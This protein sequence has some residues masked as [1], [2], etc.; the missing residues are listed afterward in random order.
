LKVEQTDEP[1]NKPDSILE[2]LI[3]AGL[4]S[5]LQAAT[6]GKAM[7]GERRVVTILFCDVQGST[8]ASQD[9]DPEEWAEI[10]NGVFEQMISPIYRYEGF[11]ARL[12]GD[13]ILAFFGAPIA[14]ED[15]P[16]RAVLAG[17]DI[18][19]AIE[20]YSEQLFQE[21]GLRLAARVGINT[22]LVVVGTVGSD[23]RMEYT[24]MGD[25]I[26]LAARMEQTAQ[27][28]SVQISAE[29]H[30][31]V[32]PYFISEDLGT[33]EIKGK[34]E[35]IQIFN[36]TAPLPGERKQPLDDQVSPLIGREAEFNAI[37]DPLEALQRGMG[38][39]VYLSGEAGL[40]KSRLVSE[41][42]SQVDPGE[43]FSWF[44]TYSLSYESSQPYASFKHL[45][46]EMINIFPDQ[47]LQEQERKI[48]EFVQNSQLDE[49]DQFIQVI[50]ALF[51]I[52]ISADQPALE[53]EGFRGMLYASTLDFW[54]T[55]AATLPVVLFFDDLQWAD[56]AT[57]G[58]LERMFSLV[59]QVPLLLICATRPERESA[60]WGS[61]LTAESKFPHRFTQIELQPLSGVHSEKLVDSLIDISSFP[62][63]MRKRILEKADGNPYF[64]EEVVRSLLDQGL[65]ISPGNG[66]QLGSA[67]L[68]EDINIPDNLQSLL[69]ARIDSLEENSRW[70]LQ[71][72]A[73]IGRKFYYQV[74]SRLVDITQGL[75]QHLVSLQRQQLIQ[76]AA[77]LPEL[78]YIFKNVLIQEAAYGTLLIREK[79]HY[80]RLVAQ[81][82]EEIFPEQT[83][84][85]API[86]AYHC[87]LGDDPQ[88]A[89]SYYRIAG[90]E[91]FRLFATGEAINHY[92][93]ALG[94]LLSLD[95]GEYQS[96]QDSRQ[97]LLKHL[98]LRKG[99]ALELNQQF[100]LA[101]SSYT[102]MLDYSKEIES[103]ALEL[104]AQTAMLTLHSIP[105]PNFDI[106][107]ANSI[108]KSALSLA[109]QLD[110]QVAEA[111]VYWSL[112]I[113]NVMSRDSKNAIGFANKSIALS[114]ELN[115][116]EQLA[117]ALNDLA[118]AYVG[119]GE[120]DKA[121]SV[122]DEAYLLFE[123]LG[124]MPML[125]DN[126]LNSAEINLALGNY[127]LAYGQYLEIVEIAEGI[128]N[129]WLKAWGLTGTGHISLEYG[130]I[131]QGLEML[132]EVVA[133]T[134]QIGIEMLAAGTRS[135]LAL[136]YA[137]LGDF[138]LA[139][140]MVEKSLEIAQ[141][142][143]YPD[144]FRTWPF[145]AAARL[146][147]L[148]GD[149]ERAEPLL[150]ESLKHYNPED[151]IIVYL[152]QVSFVHAEYLIAQGDYQKAIDEME[153]L[154]KQLRGKKVNS[155]LAEPLRLKAEAQVL[156]N[157]H[158]QALQTLL[159][160]KTASELVGERREYWKILAG[161][162][163][164]EGKNGN[165]DKA[166]TYREMARETITYITEQ[167]SESELRNKFLELPNVA[168]LISTKDE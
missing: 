109:A 38:G 81:A 139:N 128:D 151:Y 48:A 1:K 76:E 113:L 80:H 166:E 152:K 34:N 16:Q 44:E 98:Y 129:G 70:I 134:D 95:P 153:K 90:D 126:I 69:L 158:E 144:Y 37:N 163:E 107:R 64:V 91:A 66:S 119:L 71:V 162:A 52:Q 145:S 43:K 149:F 155:L 138:A 89:L 112:T 87:E 17:L 75:D 15:D 5:K 4:A 78:E 58:L 141:S 10:M 157:Q 32:A 9:M 96:D 101:V 159:E 164:L 54:R 51:G 84:E 74:L 21:R 40:G 133:I 82:L 23:L 104:A 61:M 156:N 142:G 53:G 46:R 20:K 59:D 125:G 135:Q 24:A 65:T 147:I 77:R 28:G 123:R 92:S 136:A 127:E 57:V 150:K 85:Y 106:K 120:F 6:Q 41:I 68:P 124:D 132:T 12:M 8:S 110:D 25:A 56:P 55:Q 121:Q 168:G 103:I 165:A 11:V 140:E 19:R 22:G 99:R 67:A 60:G 130:N 49:P 18:T 117:Y 73:V 115:L 118:R 137:Y 93:K 27:P 45:M 111:K 42:K 116:D 30:K 33:M 35:P 88:R 94:I 36:V 97:E 3:P 26:N 148:Q 105:G 14:H 62:T 160:A 167:I 131:S 161:L 86:L 50:G 79:K 108:S 102:E 100:D 143:T 146:F 31:L 29:T 122:A 72:A 7:V 39:I 114:R 154:V 2:R 83:T 13:S 47:D 63:S